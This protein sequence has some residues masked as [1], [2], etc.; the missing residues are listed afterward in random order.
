MDMS[1]LAASHQGLSL[2]ILISTQRKMGRTRR[3]TFTFPWCL[4]PFQM[5]KPVDESELVI[6][7][8]MLKGRKY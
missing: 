5:R 6:I 8:H 4:A 3:E 1:V 2:V 7:S